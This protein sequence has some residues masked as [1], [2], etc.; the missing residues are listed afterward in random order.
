MERITD[1]EKLENVRRELKLLDA[2]KRQVIAETSELRGLTNQ[3]KRI[4]EALW[5]TEDEIRRCERDKDFGPQFI[6]LARSVYRQN[7]RRA[8]VKRRI[9]EVLGSDLVEEKNYVDYDA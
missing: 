8:A 6:E 4:N 9:N 1:P 7:D 5:L 3:L 2:T